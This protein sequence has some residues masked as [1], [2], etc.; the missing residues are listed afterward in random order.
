LAAAWLVDKN[1][2]E[3]QKKVN[4]HGDDGQQLGWRAESWP[5][6][7]PRTAWRRA[8]ESWTARQDLCENTASVRAARLA[9]GR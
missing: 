3:K 8:P 9:R 7:R 1:W 6:R 5:P 2:Q 4:A